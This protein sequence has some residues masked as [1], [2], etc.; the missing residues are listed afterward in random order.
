MSVY[1]PFTT[2]DVII[3]PH[4]LNK[5][6]RYEGEVVLTKLCCIRLEIRWFDRGVLTITQIDFT[7]TSPTLFTS[8][9][10]LGIE[11]KIIKIQNGWEIQ[12]N[13]ST[14]W[15][16]I[17]STQNNDSC[18]LENWQP[19]SYFFFYWGSESTL[20]VFQSP[21]CSSLLSLQY[22]SGIDV[23][24]GQ[25]NPQTPWNSNFIPTGFFTPTDPYLVY[26]SIRELYYYNYISGSMGS[27]INQPIINSDGTIVGENY[28]PNG[29]NYL[30]SNININREFPTG[31]NSQIG[32]IS[33]PSNL[34]GEFIK[35][36]TFRWEV[37]SSQDF[38]LHDDGEGNILLN[39]NYYSS[40]NS[41][42]GNIIYE[43]GIVIINNEL[44]PIPNSTYG[45]AVYGG[46]IYGGVD[47]NDFLFNTFVTC[48]F[49]STIT[50]YESQYKCSIRENE[51]NF[52]N[53][54]TLISG[55]SNIGELK[56]FA[57]SSYF[58]PYV[59]TVGLYNNDK[60]LIAV[61]KLAQPLPISPT[62]DTNIIINLDL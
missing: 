51:F 10:T 16:T 59:S 43:H 42:V 61:A 28:T 55:S 13:D 5:Q 56:F 31:S 33:I 38:I 37:S 39:S 26:R 29:Y 47:I 50:I 46:G 52:S 19:T 54:P 40:S 62:T 60:E 48:S 45:G 58:S 15:E 18:P 17:A 6:F 44:L 20:N 53:N 23:F 27:P 8:E 21:N 7:Q 35:P 25:N 9:E 57:T 2:S 11:F 30:S 22:I 24:I 49:E 4:I 41:H 32:V 34:Y 36:T 1:K 14:G 12:Q 3:S